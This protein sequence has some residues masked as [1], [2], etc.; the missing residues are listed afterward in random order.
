MTR[1]RLF[2]AGTSIAAVGLAVFAAWNLKDK[3]NSLYKPSSQIEM[4]SEHSFEAE[5]ANG[6]AQW[7]FQR[8]Q[9]GNGQLDLNDVYTMEQRARQTY[10]AQQATARSA[11]ST[12]AINWNEIGPDNVGGRTRALLM[13]RNNSQHMF[14]GG[15]SGG[16]WESTD[17]GNN[18]SKCAG[19]FAIPQVNLN[20]VS[21]AQGSDNAIYVGTGEGLYGGNTFNVSGGGAGG[22][23]GGGMYK[24]TDGG[25]TFTLL[26]NTEPTTSNSG[27]SPWAAINKIGV[28][29]LNSQLV[30]AATNRGIRVSNDGGQNWTAPTSPPVG[31][32]GSTDVDFDS[33]GNLIVCVSGKPYRSTDNAVT[34]TNISGPTSGFFQGGLSRTEIGIAPSDPNWIYAFCAAVG[35][36]VLAGAYISIDGGTSWTQIAGANSPSFAPFGDNGQGDYDNVCEVDPYDKNHC[37]FGGV[38]FWEWNNITVSPSSSNPPSGQWTRIASEFPASIFNPTYVHSD[39]HAV[40]FHPTQQGVYYVGTDGGIFRT[41]NNGLTYVPMNA[42]YSVT[43]FYGVSFDHFA[44][45]RNIALGGTQDNGTQFI[46][47]LGNTIKSSVLVKGGDGAH[48]EMSY[49]NPS[50]HFSTSYYGILSRSNNSSNSYSDFYSGRV[51]SLAGFENPGFAAFI[52]PVRLWESLN[53]PTSID[54]VTIENLNRA[55]IAGVGDGSNT[56]LSYSISLTGIIPASTPGPSV[57]PSTVIVS[58]GQ[59]TLT[60]DILGNLSG[61]GTGT[62]SASGNVIAT[63]NSAPANGAPI[64]ISYGLRYSAGTTF[65]LQSAQAPTRFFQYVTPNPILSNTLTKVQDPINARFV[66]GLASQGSAIGGVMLTKGALDFSATPEWIKIAGSRST[67]SAFSGTTSALAWSTD[68]NLLY[69]GTDGGRLYR[70]SNINAVVD[71]ANGDVDGNANATVANANCVVRCTQ[72]ANFPSRII[73]AIDVDFANPGRVI[74][75]LGNYSNSQ[76]IYLSTT[77]DVDTI[78]PDAGSFVNRTGNMLTLGAVPAYSVSLDKYNPNRVLVGTERGLIETTNINSPVWAWALG[79]LNDQVAVDMIRQQ[80]WDPWH[81]QNAGCFYIGT[82]GRGIWRD[83]SSW[84]QPNSVNEPGQYS[85][86]GA[87]VNAD[88][89]I[90]PNPVMESATVAFRLPKAGDVQLKVYDLSGKLMLEQQFDQLLSGENK[91]SFNAQEFTKGTYLVLITQNEQRVGTSRFVKMNQ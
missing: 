90:F 88:L 42:G 69:V 35:Q 52:T 54:S 19:Y 20:V 27:S 14:A 33:N 86:A 25:V 57:D 70:I 45:G 39:K 8:M 53:N 6:A 55:I 71:S 9:S 83:D 87:T 64:R 36:S 75:A 61:D 2:I 10:R 46:D 89:R 5:D 26:Q 63:F 51:T 30:V 68:G 32:A 84:Q 11:S 13:D 37:V 28:S 34:F 60:G 74:V 3:Q 81:A 65:Q 78:N 82:H 40:L 23:L 49:L 91:I 76:Y 72:I 38:E 79:G 17:G 22:F 56:A 50:A 31:T 44:P 7:R 66:V 24:S 73:T 21:I 16:L 41:L 67:P 43:Q 77:A 18:W 29:P 1:N 15:V 85:G 12:V 80:R 47:G 58:S 62:V 48:S 4:K 59:D